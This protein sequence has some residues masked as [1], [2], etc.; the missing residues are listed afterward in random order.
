M[1]LLPHAE[2]AGAK[3]GVDYCL[4]LGTLDRETLCGN[5]PQ[6][7]HMGPT[8]TGD[9]AP[10]HWRRYVKRQDAD[11]FK[12]WTA[13]WKVG[14]AEPPPILCLPSDG[15]GWGRGL[16]QIDFAADTVW[17][18]QKLPDGRFLW[19]DAESNIDKV[20]ELL[21]AGIVTFDGDEWLAAA[22]YNAG[23]ENVR[24]ALLLVPVDSTP[25]ERHK[26]ADEVTTGRDYAKDVI[27]RRGRFAQQLAPQP[28]NG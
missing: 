18:L 5:S 12:H 21:Q 4:I 17:C 20:A 15:R 13:D 19:E 22:S 28:G 8:G 11:N 10:R 7:D 27:S 26:C 16:G 25:E 2:Q 3:W 6:L 9:F 24:K 1:A 14:D 23:P